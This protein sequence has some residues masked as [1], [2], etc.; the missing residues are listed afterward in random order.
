M[1]DKMVDVGGRRRRECRKTGPTMSA[2]DTRR[3]SV[4]Y[5]SVMLDAHDNNGGRNSI[6]QAWGQNW[7][8]SILK[9]RCWA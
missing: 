7:T 6:E 5:P 8:F 2:A 4:C 1:T 3:H 9:L